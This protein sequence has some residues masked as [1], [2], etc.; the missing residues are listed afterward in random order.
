MKKT[1]KWLVLSVLFAGLSCTNLQIEPTDSNFT[2]LSGEFTGVDPAASL[3]GLYNAVRG[4]L[5]DQAN[6]YALT[7]ISSD[8]LVVPTR[9]TDWGDN[10]VW[11][12]LHD[13]NWDATHSFI[14]NTWNNLNQNVYNATLIIDSR[15]NPSAQQIAEAK[16]LR[17]FNTYWLTDFYGQAPFRSPDEGADV[18]PTVKTRAEAFDFA[19][20][21]LTEAIPDLPTVGPSMALN[22]AS[23]ASAR[24][25]LAKLYLNKFVF[26]ATSPD[27]SDMNKVI[28]NVDAIAADGFGLQAGY[29][30]LFKDAVNSETIYFTTASVGNRMWNSL[31]YK[32]NAPGN[33]GGGWNG[34]TTLSEFYDTFEGDPN[35]NVPGSGQEERRGFVPTD[36]SHFGIGYGFLVGQ[37]YDETG[38]A[39]TDRTGKPLIFTRELPGLLGNNESTGIR[40]L[41]Y[42]P[43]NGA[44]A[45]HEVVFRYADAHLM[46]AEAIMRG[47]TAGSTPLGMVNELRALREAAPMANVDEQAMLDE[48]GRELYIESWRRNDQIRFGKFAEPWQYKTN[49][50]EYRNLYP[51]PSTALISNPNLIQNPGY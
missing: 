34:F 47:G 41:K 33:D 44:F 37:Q 20:Q 38:T 25:L 21:D 9:G 50:D 46:K 1:M 22:K 43:E 11:R 3:D 2:T 10:G 8:E 5:E 19:V 26:L 13:H 14:K 28:E 35:I 12:N 15:S 18:N 45:N 48:R 36:G 32:Q 27:A 29:F 51:I 31:H 24:F 40:L 4:Q 6:F 17:A 23:K 30:D 16:F 49:T 42:N 39:M 7:E